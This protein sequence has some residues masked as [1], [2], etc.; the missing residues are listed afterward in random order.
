MKYWLLM[1]KAREAFLTFQT[2]SGLHPAGFCLFYLVG[3][4]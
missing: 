2:H 4:M 1:Q 3:L